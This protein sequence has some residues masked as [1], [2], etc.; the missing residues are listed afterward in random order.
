[1]HENAL[2]SHPGVQIGHNLSLSLEYADDVATWADRTGLK[3][4]TEKTKFMVIN[5]TDPIS[6]TVNQVQ[7]D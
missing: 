4:S 7:L 3:V 5:L 2:S 6:L 1:M